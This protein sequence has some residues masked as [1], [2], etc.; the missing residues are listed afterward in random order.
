MPRIRLS[1]TE[2]RRRKLALKVDRLDRL[3]SRS[4]V[5]PFN[6]FSLATGAFQGLSQLGMMRSGGSGSALSG[7]V[8]PD[9]AAQGA[10]IQSRAVRS[11]ARGA[12]GDFPPI[13]IAPA[14][15]SAAG[16][17]GAPAAQEVAAPARAKAPA[18]D[19][20][21]KA[22]SPSSDTSSST[23]ISTPWKPASRPGGGAALPPRGGSGNGALPTTLSAV[24]GHSPWS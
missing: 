23:G 4:T 24:Q 21:T 18:D 14:P 13:N 3:E 20:L 12:S 7:P 19:E 11:Q 9:A 6:A 1:F 15:S 5:T 17:G 8:Q 2:H 10:I 16:G 22:L